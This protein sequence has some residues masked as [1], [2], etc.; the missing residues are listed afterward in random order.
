MGAIEFPCMQK[1]QRMVRIK[2]SRQVQYPDPISVT[3]GEAVLVGSEDGEF[4]GWRWCKASN[5]RE[6]WIPVE[7]L[8]NKGAEAT[9]LENY[10]ARELAV[11]SGE[12]V[13]IEDMRQDWL[14]V[15][16]AKGERGWIPASHTEPLEAG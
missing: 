2:V 1:V 3:A 9:V 5:G 7:L 13:T 12:Q 4:P 8:S 16:N 11:E 15:R 6:G 10:S 14:L